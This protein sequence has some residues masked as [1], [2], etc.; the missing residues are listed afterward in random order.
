MTLLQVGLPV[1][2]KDSVIG[3]DLPKRLAGPF[4]S[5]SWTSGGDLLSQPHC[6]RARALP[7][8]LEGKEYLGGSG[9][10]SEAG[11]RTHLRTARL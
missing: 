10:C 7:S 6:G 9:G 1:C 3:Q 8:C 4:G 5:E 2:R 11:G